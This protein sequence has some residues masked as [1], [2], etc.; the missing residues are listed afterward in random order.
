MLSC[1]V[2]CHVPGVLILW[3]LQSTDWH[4]IWIGIA[5]EGTVAPYSILILFNALAYVCISVDQT[6]VFAWIAIKI[7]RK[8]GSSG[9][10][11]FLYFYATAS[12]M[13]IVTSNDV[14][15]LTLTPIIYYTC[16]CT[17]QPPLPFLI[18]GN[19]KTCVSM[20]DVHVRASQHGCCVMRCHSAHALWLASCM[21]CD[22]RCAVPPC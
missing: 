4:T 7:A 8:A 17:D 12:V 15:I 19:S 20:I 18:A 13:A 10:R 14:T 3:I 9:P 11:L 1:Y 22:M 16:I 2:S 6:G 21:S 5:G